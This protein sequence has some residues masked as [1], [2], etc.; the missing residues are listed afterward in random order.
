MGR[1]ILRLQ[2]VN[3]DPKPEFAMTQPQPSSHQYLDAQKGSS[4]K[5]FCADTYQQ[6]VR[7]LD[8]VYKL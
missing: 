8:T 5:T 2:T 4:E 6:L 1:S 7:E 3:V